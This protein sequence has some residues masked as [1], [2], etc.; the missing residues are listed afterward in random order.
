MEKSRQ[1]FT[2]PNIIST[3]RIFLAFPVYYYLS[4]QENN[5]AMVYILIALFTDVLDGFIA[6]RFNQISE[7]GKIL[8][9]LADKM[10]IAGAF[11]ALALYQEFPFWIM[12]AIIGRDVL[13]ILGS[14]LLAGK[15][16]IILPSNVPGKMTVFL[17]SLYGI[18]YILRI[19]IL[20]TPLLVLVTIFIL[21]S[22]YYYLRVFIDNISNETSS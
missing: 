3:I 18:S 9:P 2:I 20:F 7:A 19:E 1:I 10:C 22:F 5:I 8:D 6:R 14:L 17:I 12:I 11:I 21:I 15:N 13:I 4:I 16:N